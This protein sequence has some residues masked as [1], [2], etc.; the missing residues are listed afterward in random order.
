MLV[1]EQFGLRNFEFMPHGP[2]KL[3]GTRLLL[4]GTQ[5]HEDHAGLGSAMTDDLIRTEMELIK[6][7]VRILSGLLII[8]N[9]LS[10]WICATN[11]AFSSGKRYP[12]AAAD[13]GATLPGSGAQHAEG[14]DRSA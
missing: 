2:F 4:R 12:G 10:C 14:D 13:S 1:V 9:H 6:A 7:M 8:N 5:R 3:N 11:W